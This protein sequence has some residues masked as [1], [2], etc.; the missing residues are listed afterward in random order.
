MRIVARTFLVLLALVAVA[1]AA[2]LLLPRD[3]APKLIGRE[4]RID[5]WIGRVLIGIVNTYLEPQL[6]FVAL[7]YTPPGAVQLRDAALTARDGTRVMAFDAFGLT[8]AEM[9][10]YGEPVVIEE[11][12]LGRGTVNLIRDPLGGGFRGLT[13]FVKAGPSQ[14]F[15]AAAPAPAPPTAQPRDELPHRF[16]LSDVLRL[17]RIE[18]RELALRYDPGD[19]RP[20]MVLDGITTTLTIV[21][22]TE[23]AE[24]G[25][26]ALSCNMDR[27]DLFRLTFAGRLNLDTFVA[28]VDA[29][30][31][32]LTVSPETIARLPPELQE[33]LR[34]HEAAGRLTVYLHGRIPLTRWVDGEAQIQVELEEFEVAAGDYR[35]P[36]D[37]LTTEMKLSGGRL[38]LTSLLAKLL[39]G[40]LRLKGYIDVGGDGRPASLEWAADDVDLNALLRRHGRSEEE[41]ASELTGRLST[42]GVVNATLADAPRS[43]SGAGQV[44]IRDGRLLWIPIVQQLTD[45]MRSAMR[46]PAGRG[47]P[48]HRADIAFNF[49]TAGVR[50]TRGEVRTTL[51]AARGTGLV[52]YD[53]SLDLRVHAGPLERLQSLLGDIGGAI[54]RA[55]DRLVTYHIT[56]TMRQPVVSVSVLESP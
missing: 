20:P 38:E 24:P 22:D 26:Y 39:K 31:L 43:L 19:G 50:V 21:P 53:G 30:R 34:R 36:I 11:V 25:W 42:L 41:Q 28:D 56:G 5:D 51:L 27:G 7:D 18:V 12:S 48:D 40:T 54:A 4:G 46:L 35:L 49:Q 9:P 45:A 2:F 37:G 10:R 1:L 15:T 33:L 23:Q 29:A 52:G 55:T 3:V 14:S 17:R 47:Q 44:R 13:P 6:S 16:Q 32:H 8:L